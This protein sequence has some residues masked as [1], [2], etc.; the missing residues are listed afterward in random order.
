[1]H[2]FLSLEW[3]NA[4]KD[5]W[6]TKQE[7]IDELK[8]FNASIKY[9]IDGKE[10]GIMLLVK[11]G[12]ADDVAEAKQDSYDFEMWADINI[13]K[14][15]ATGDLGPKSALLTKKLKFK[16]SMITAMK[17]MSAFEKSITMMSEIP[18]NFEL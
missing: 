11:N 1:M 5:L 6:N 16:G 12:V 3:M 8:G 9:K 10:P 2:K 4:Y 18:A 15:L 13:W 17:Y 14:R 7:L